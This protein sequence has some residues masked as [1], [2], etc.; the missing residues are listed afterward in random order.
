MLEKAGW[1]LC[2]LCQEKEGD[3]RLCLQHFVLFMT[4]TIPI[5]DTEPPT[6]RVCVSTPINLISI[7]LS[8]HD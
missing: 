4:F 5:Y 3:E 8:R 2:V 6:I 7:I 1:S